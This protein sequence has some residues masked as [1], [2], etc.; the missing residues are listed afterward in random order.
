MLAITA[1]ISAMA[2][3]AFGKVSASFGTYSLQASVVGLAR[4][5]DR[6]FLAFRRFVLE[7]AV[8]GEEAHLVVAEKGRAT[9]KEI[10][11]RALY[12]IKLPERI[13]R[14]KKISEDFEGY[15][16]NFDKLVALRREQVKETKEVLDPSGLKLRTNFEELQGAAARSGSSNMLTLAGEGLKHLMLARLNVNKL[17]GRRDDAAATEA[18]K[19]FA[20]LKSVIAGLDS[21]TKGIDARKMFDDIRQLVDKYHDGYVKASHDAHEIDVLRNGEMKKMA[22]SIAADAQWV[23]DGS[24]ADEKQIEQDTESLVASTE[25]FVV[26]LA[27]GGLIVGIVLAWLIG[28]GISLPLVGLRGG[29]EKLANGDFNTVL[30][31]L[32]RKDE[33]GE[34][35][36]A[37]EGFKVK[38]AEKARLEAGEQHARERAAAT[39]KKAAE[40]R[41]AAEKQAAAAREETARKAAMVKLAN[42]FEAAV[43]GII[44][45]VSSASTE[46]EAAANTLTRTADTTQQL[47]TVVASASEEASANVQSVASATEEM[48]SSIGEI[49]RQV[50]ES[51]SIAGEAVRQAQQTDARINELSVAA[52]R[53]GDVV[54]LITA[55]AEQTN[56]LALNATIEAAR[57]GEA[58]RG[59]AVVAQEVKALAAQTAKATDEIGTQIAGMQTATRES[60]AAIKEIGGTIGRISEISSTIAAAV[61]EQGAATGEI[62]RNVGQAAKG[63]AQVASNI[64]DVN[65]GASETGSASAQVLSSAQS[66]SSE[67]NRL[68]MEVGKF[69]DTVRAA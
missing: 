4:D 42:E 14:M 35:A 28:R 46:L 31:G 53:I 13:A 20:D 24:M 52:S 48:S 49:S 10:I 5:V 1:V 55:I 26:L 47:S 69:L 65:R 59:F 18:D 45:T 6:E 58:G 25:H 63:T 9:V 60:V 33:I 12:T 67:S 34:I 21:A 57:A 17:L 68:K 38:S 27:I 30:P 22:E 32:G 41:E 23:K 16:K 43:G 54:K 40:E 62:S 11:A 64:T 39:E 56:L 36:Q 37:V 51:S 19:A 61:E 3:L 8:T 15:G 44:E 2:Y 66:L 29:M 7:Y 50:Q